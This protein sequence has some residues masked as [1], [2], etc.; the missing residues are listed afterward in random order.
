MKIKTNCFGIIVTLE[1]GGGSITSDLQE[2]EMSPEYSGAVDAIES[3]VLAH[4]MA[5]IDIT[6]AAYLEGI[7]TAVIG[8]ANNL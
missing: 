8:C 3:L 7:E 1:D 2:D 5:G 6:S 4:A